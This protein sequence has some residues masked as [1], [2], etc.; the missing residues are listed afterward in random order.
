MDTKHKKYFMRVTVVV[1]V[2]AVLIGV[3][4]YYEVRQYDESIL[5]IY[6]EQQDSY[7]KLVLDQINLQKDRTDDEMI[8]ELSRIMSGSDTAAD[9]T[10]ADASAS[11]DT[12]DA[13]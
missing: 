12:T 10:S 7:V 1:F 8:D 13:E 2:I 6:A 9:S 4:G 5:E 11:S 3:F